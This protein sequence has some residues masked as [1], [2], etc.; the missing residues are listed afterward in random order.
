MDWRRSDIGGLREASLQS[1]SSAAARS[2]NCSVKNGWYRMSKRSS[3]RRSPPLHDFRRKA[4]AATL[5]ESEEPQEL[6]IESRSVQKKVTRAWAPI[7][8]GSLLLWGD[9]PDLIAEH[10]RLMRKLHTTLQLI[11]VE[12]ES[13]GIS[14]GDRPG[15]RSP[16]AFTELDSLSPRE[17]QVV[18]ML[19]EGHR[20]ST[21]ARNSSISPRTV[22]N[23]LQSI[24]RKLNVNSQV[25]LIEK[26]KDPPERYG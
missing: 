23:R 2:S 24:Y 14:P 19:L 25:E 17:A 10:D 12:L 11:H 13:L 1:A 15:P 6:G 18:Q 20:V 21:I 9:I 4:P 3:T 22:R 16:E 8:L 7:V 5:E 26:F